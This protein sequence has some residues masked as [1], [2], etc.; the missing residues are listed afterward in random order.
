MAKKKLHTNKVWFILNGEPI[1]CKGLIPAED[2]YFRYTKEDDNNKCAVIMNNLVYY[3]N[4][5]VTKE[6]QVYE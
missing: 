4:Y 1:E 2:K 5:D 3:A 6:F